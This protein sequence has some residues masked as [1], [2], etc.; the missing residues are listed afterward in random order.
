VP[1][2][3]FLDA[4]HLRAVVAPGTVVI[5]AGMLATSFGK[6]YWQSILA[7]GVVVVPF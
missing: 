2:S 5:V 4:G 6:E 1:A 3:R 7:Q